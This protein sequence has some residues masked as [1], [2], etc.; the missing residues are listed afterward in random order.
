MTTTITE[1]R[2]NAREAILMHGML[3]GIIAGLIFAMAEMMIN[4]LLGKSFLDPLRLIGSMGLSTR[5]LDPDY[6]F[7]AAGAVGLIIHLILSAIYG[8]IFVGMI[9]LTGQLNASSRAMLIYGW[10]FGLALW[11]VNFM[12]IA[13][14]AFRQF[15]EVDQ[16]WNGLVAHTF[17]FGT[18]LGALTAVSRPKRLASRAPAE[19]AAE[20]DRHA[21]SRP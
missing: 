17:F 1:N 8:V 10:L 3:L 21:A 5:A 12:I 2:P 15:T 19:S 13:P 16:L 14:A 9:G 4:A 20:Y 6:S 11:I 7:V 18:V